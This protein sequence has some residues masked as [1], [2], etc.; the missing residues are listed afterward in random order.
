MLIANPFRQLALVGFVFAAALLPV[1]AQEGP[2]APPAQE[3]P[4]SIY[5]VN[6]GS[7]T[8]FGPVRR[9]PPLAPAEFL[10]WPP[11]QLPGLT[12][13]KRS[14]QVSLQPPSVAAT[15]LV[16]GDGP[17]C[18]RSVWV[19]PNIDPRFAR[20]IFGTGGVIRREV[21]PPCVRTTE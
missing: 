5:P 14:P 6:P 12:L 10:S 2:Q 8:I 20:P 11:E 19:D 16:N 1:H 15:P 9:T 7:P 17:V 3:P 13:R 4:A 18:L 21:M